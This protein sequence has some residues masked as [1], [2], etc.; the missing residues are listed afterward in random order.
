[1][2]PPT[3]EGQLELFD[4]TSRPAQPP[5]HRE[6][7]GRLLLQLRYD[8]LVVAGIC[9]LLGVTV[10]FASGV[11]RGKRL[12][13]S[14]RML[15][16]RQQ[17]AAAQTP[18][19]SSSRPSAEDAAI[20]AAPSATMGTPLERK[21]APAPAATQKIKGPS[22]LAADSMGSSGQQK[23]TEKAAG[24][25]RYAIQVVTFSRPHLAKR[26]LDRLQAVGERAFLVMREGRTVVYV[27][28]FPSKMN[29]S[30][31]L[32]QLRSRYEDCFVK[33]L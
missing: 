1:M 18:A 31:K 5:H 3:P 14:E 30:A 23:K 4:L 11:E 7:V 13:R 32:T 33:T 20:P 25:S 15:L 29:A 12:V 2:V 17:P 6:A 10:I 19:P 26:E 16:A 9:G 21:G 8:Q 27:G 24:R 22:K 28:P